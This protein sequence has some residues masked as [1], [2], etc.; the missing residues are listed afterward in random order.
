MHNAVLMDRRVFASD[1]SLYSSNI[2]LIN[3]HELRH[4]PIFVYNSRNVWKELILLVRWHILF[5]GRV[6]H[7]GFRYTAY[8]F[9]RDLY[10]TGWVANLSDG[11]VEMEIQGNVSQIRKLLVRLKAQ[12][13]MRILKMDISEIPV[14]P[15]E[16]RFEVKESHD[17]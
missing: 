5:Y 7:V 14:V 4:P 17:F 1:H 9:T 15:Y 6:Q 3:R 12:P 11:R 10:L 16:R 8:Y 2:G 13:N